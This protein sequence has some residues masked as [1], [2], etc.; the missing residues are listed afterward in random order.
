MDLALNNLQ[1]LM[2]HKTQT[3][4]ITVMYCSVA[5]SWKKLETKRQRQE[6]K[7]FR[8]VVTE[9]TT[10]LSMVHL[11]SA[12]VSNTGRCEVL[13]LWGF[14]KSCRRQRNND[15]MDKRRRD[16]RKKEQTRSHRK[17]HT[18]IDGTMSLWTGIKF[19][20]TL[21]GI[22]KPIKERCLLKQIVTN[23]NGS[24]PV[25]WCCRIHRLLLCRGVDPAN[26]CPEYDTK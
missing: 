19:R 10:H 13:G 8:H 25:N 2:C 7:K 22:I 23:P 5:K 24:C 14:E 6:E 4:I 12:P 3:V 16:K 17:S 9:N 15:N 18:F 20:K 26:K 1:R 11:S 21:G